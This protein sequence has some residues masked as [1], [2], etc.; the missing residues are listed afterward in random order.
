VTSLPESSRILP[1]QIVQ[2]NSHGVH[3]ECFS[4]SQLFVDL[5]GVECFR[6]PHFQLVD[7]GGRKKIAAHQPRLLP[8]PFVSL[9]LAP[10]RWGT[11][12]RRRK[13]KYEQPDPEMTSH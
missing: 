13:H 3:A 12:R 1:E 10:A 8:V 11:L 2:K 4:P 5:L 9:G 6:L 7:R